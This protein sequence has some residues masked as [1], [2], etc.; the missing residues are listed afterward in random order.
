MGGTVR[1]ESGGE[2][3]GTTV[4]LRL[5]SAQAPSGEPPVSG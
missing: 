1:L 2:G 4:T 5:V 3:K